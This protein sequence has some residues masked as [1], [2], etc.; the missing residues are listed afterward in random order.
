MVSAT[1]VQTCWSVYDN[2][3]GKCVVLRHVRFAEIVRK[4]AGYGATRIER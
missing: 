1:L 3:V 2:T 4:T